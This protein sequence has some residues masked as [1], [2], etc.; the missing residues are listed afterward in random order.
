MCR[1]P[2]R[3]EPT[4]ASD[5]RCSAPSS[6]SELVTR[7][8]HRCDDAGECGSGDL[9]G[10][11]HG[12]A[13]TPLP[14]ARRAG[15]AAVSGGCPQSLL[16]PPRRPIATGRRRQSPHQHQSPRRPPPPLPDHLDH[17]LARGIDPIFTHVAD[18]GAGPTFPSNRPRAARCRVRWGG[19]R[20]RV[21]LADPP[22]LRTQ[23]WRLVR[24][25]GVPAVTTWSSDGARMDLDG[26]D[27]DRPGRARGG[28]T[29]HPSGARI[30]QPGQW[31]R[32]ACSSSGSCTTAARSTGPG[33]A[34]DRRRG[35]RAAWSQ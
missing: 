3:R 31:R 21:F 14:A 29:H 20:G 8:Q 22:G 23:R 7:P 10:L 27:Q 33:Q 35:A 11:A 26:W 28:M 2:L 13:V 32:H 19:G 24:P 34:P 9:P 1:C 6:R 5:T 17:P 25:G 12:R 30:V 18:P 4:S 15:P 16:R